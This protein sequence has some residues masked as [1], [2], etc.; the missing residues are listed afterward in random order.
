MILFSVLVTL[1]HSR[2]E[3][4]ACSLLKIYK[5]KK[6]ILFHARRVSERTFFK[7]FLITL[8]KLL[9]SLKFSKLLRARVCEQDDNKEKFETKQKLSF[10]CCALVII[11]VVVV[12]DKLNLDE[13]ACNSYFKSHFLLSLM[14]LT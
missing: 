1:A 8:Q 5:Y 12:V 11:A 6:K 9:L 13:H 10:C 2:V 4:H 3:L 14:A 7:F